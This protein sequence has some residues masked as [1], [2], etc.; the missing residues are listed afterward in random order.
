MLLDGFLFNMNE[1]KERNIVIDACDV[2]VLECGEYWEGQN[3]TKLCNK[4][5]NT[6]SW[7][8]LIL[9][10]SAKLFFILKTFLWVVWRWCLLV[11]FAHSVSPHS[12]EK[13]VSPLQDSFTEMTGDLNISKVE[14]GSIK[15]Q[16]RSLK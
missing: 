1:N 11:L 15:K 2:F 16:E 9:W 8:L 7:D 14:Y 10:M 3:Y 4:K 12:L 6:S 13:R 5:N